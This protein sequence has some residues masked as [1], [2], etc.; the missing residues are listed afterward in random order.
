MADCI[1]L[2]FDN[3][4]PSE[5]ELMAK[6]FCQLANSHFEGIEGKIYV[7]PNLKTHRELDLVVWMTFPKFKPTIKTSHQSIDA[8][9]K[10]IERKTL[11][12][13]KDIWFSSSLM[14]LELKKLIHKQTQIPSNL[15]PSI[16]KT[17]THSNKTRKHSIFFYFALNLI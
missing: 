12:T 10:Q 13:K 15:Q 17:R 4:D 1:P 2:V 14:I 7:L 16:P 11:R 6:M 8:E 3:Y 5:E 9:S